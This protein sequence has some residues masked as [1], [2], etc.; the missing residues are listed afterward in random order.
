MYKTWDSE[1]IVYD[2]QLL[3]GSTTLASTW[4]V[5]LS[6]NSSNSP[7][8]YKDAPVFRLYIRR[9]WMQAVCAYIKYQELT[10]SKAAVAGKKAK[11][12]AINDE[13]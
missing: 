13:D 1:S 3:K 6:K 8:E 5:Q 9:N 4:N 7:T 12:W 2:V 11:V 10:M